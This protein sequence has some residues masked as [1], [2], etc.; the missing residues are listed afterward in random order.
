LQRMQELR[1]RKAQAAKSL[2]DEMLSDEGAQ[3]AMTMLDWEGREFEV[4][5]GVKE[6]ISLDDMLAS[7]RTTDTDTFSDLEIFVRDS[8]DDLFYYLEIFEHYISRGLVDFMDLEHPVKYY[9]DLMAANRPSFEYYLREYKF[10][11]A[12]A[13]LERF[14][15]WRAV[16]SA[17]Q[18]PQL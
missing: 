18:L 2:N 3:V 11:L 13:F 16:G 10:E 12:S 17:A 1:W 15:S 14:A 7:L 5:T 4:Q 9:I 8:F 6:S